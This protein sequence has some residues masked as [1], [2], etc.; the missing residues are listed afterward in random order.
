MTDW[1]ITVLTIAATVYGASAGAKLRS[2]RAFLSFRAGLG[3]TALMPG[4][5]LS[6][7]A[8]ALAAGEAAVAGLAI[9]A[10][11][12]ATLLPGSAA[13]SV[14]AL[15]GATLLTSVLA[16]GVAT[17]MRRGTRAR[18]A[19]FGSGSGRPLGGVHLIRNVSLL[20]VIVAGLTGGL[21][22]LGGGLGHGRPGL[23]GAAVAVVAG[24][25]AGLLLARFDDLIALF[26]PIAPA[27]TSAA[28][29]A[30]PASGAVRSR[31][32]AARAASYDRAPG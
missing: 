15:A 17:V 3:E 30:T 24:C 7:T 28:R 8:V 2:R 27:S 31:P 6:L 10:V 4:R 32:P 1:V 16:A 18:C 19:C 20:A 25:V 12:T 26:T 23:A 29:T 21:G 14:A 22:G 11:G 13:I 5:R 9:A